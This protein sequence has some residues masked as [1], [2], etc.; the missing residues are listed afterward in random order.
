MDNK[1]AKKYPLQ[2]AIST[3]FIVIT[4]LLGVILS[5]QSFNKTSEI[6]LK[7]ADDLYERI[8]QELF[9]DFKATYGTIAG[10]LRQFRLSPVIKAK[11]FAERVSYQSSFKAVLQSDPSLFAAI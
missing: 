3:L 5:W 1:S 2:V 9:L 7:S 6:M 4:V 10:G 11:T 8:S